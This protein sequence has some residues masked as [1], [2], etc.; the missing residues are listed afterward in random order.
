[1]KDYLKILNVSIDELEHILG[2][3]IEYHN[4][5]GLII[6]KVKYPD[7]YINAY[8]YF[9]L[10]QYNKECILNTEAEN[11]NHLINDYNSTLG[12]NGLMFNIDDDTVKYVN[13]CKLIQRQNKLKKLLSCTMKTENT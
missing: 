13:Y 8:K 3:E 12:E 5:L 1:M 2:V 6:K 10:N 7:A 4:K 11:N 9:Y